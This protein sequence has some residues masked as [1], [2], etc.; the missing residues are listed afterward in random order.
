MLESHITACSKTPIVSAKTSKKALCA[1]V[2]YGRAL[3]CRCPREA[4]RTKALVRT[5]PSD[6][7]QLAARRVAARAVDMRLE[8]ERGS[9]AEGR[10]GQ[11]VE[12]AAKIVGVAA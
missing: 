3:E 9:L 1:A 11:R 8:A 5:L 12:H 6:F 7:D 10:K 4:S 2:S